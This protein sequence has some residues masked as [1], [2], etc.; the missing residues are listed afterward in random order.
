MLAAAGSGSTRTPG[1][2]LLIFSPVNDWILLETLVNVIASPLEGWNES[3]KEINKNW[4]W[5][6]G[7]VH[8]PSEI[9]IYSQGWSSLHCTLIKV[10]GKKKTLHLVQS[11]RRLLCLW[12]CEC[13]SLY[14]C[15]CAS[16]WCVYELFVSPPQALGCWVC[17]LKRLCFCC[18]LSLCFSLPLCFS[19]THRLFPCF[20]GVILPSSVHLYFLIDA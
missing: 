15:V 9:L 3:E 18:H 19:L 20:A 11:H 6:R 14:I 17:S 2:F 13:V 12:M 4:K 1:P 5:Q 16:V 10:K 8:H 7:N